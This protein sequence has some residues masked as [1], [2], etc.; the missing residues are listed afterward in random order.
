MTKQ[1]NVLLLVGGDSPERDVSMASG[2]S[3]LT[4]LET[5]GHRV[6]IVD[7]MRPEE[8][9]DRTRARLV[10]A[11]IDT[12]PPPP[13]EDLGGIRGAFLQALEKRRKKG[14]DIVFSA[15]H[16]G[17][18]EDGTVHA[19]LEYLGI[20][21][22]GSGSLASGLAM[23]KTLAK[24]LVT[25]AGVPVPAGFT[26]ET[27]N[28]IIDNVKKQIDID[29]KYPVVVKPNDQ[30]STVGFSIVHDADD[31]AGAVH[32]AA[33]FSN[34][35]VV[36]TYI[37]GFEI[38]ATVLGDECLPLLEI[39]PK[40]GV[41]DY[42]HKYTSGATEYIVPAPIDDA[43]AA[44]M[45]GH[46]IQ[47][48]RTLGCRVYARVDFRLSEDGRPFFL[49]VNT[50]PGMTSN[51]LVPKAAVAAGIDFAGLIDRILTLSLREKRATH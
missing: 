24:H 12:T 21:F 5:L 14:I 1:H 42:E 17:G 16:G 47:A 4:A 35:V 46:A 28:I 10:D 39:R 45:S 40:S 32:A 27:E 7:P 30:G 38:T 51:S 20:P 19:I 6:D 34:P 33:R 13:G 9:G 44:S 43:I 2:R 23:D 18:G 11:A 49:E 37:S 3:I 25:A 31:L 15:L 50:L 41:Y 8:T 36:E 29:L 48:F 26:V 22:T